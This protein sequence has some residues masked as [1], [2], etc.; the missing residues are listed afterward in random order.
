MAVRVDEAPYL[1]YVLLDLDASAS[2]RIF[3]WLDDPDVFAVLIV[4]AFDVLIFEI[5]D[6][7]LIFEV[8]CAA[9]DVERKW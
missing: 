3:T 1:G 2:V 6:K 4:L 9:L 5:L 7:P 8:V